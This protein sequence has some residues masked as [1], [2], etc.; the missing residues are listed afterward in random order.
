MHLTLQDLRTQYIDY[1]V[2]I[3]N[4]LKRLG[5]NPPV[6]LNEQ[7][8]DE[9]EAE[10]GLVSQKS[11]PTNSLSLLRDP[12]LFIG[13]TGA[14]ADVTH[15]K[16]GCVNEQENRALSVEIDGETSRCASQVDLPGIKCDK[17]G[18]ELQHVTLKKMRY[19]P[20]ANF[21]LLSLTK[22]LMDG[23]TMN[24]DAKEI[25]MRKGSTQIR[26]DIVIKT[27]RGAIF[28]TYIKHRTVPDLQRGRYA[29]S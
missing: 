25:V 18:N 26:F 29:S 13:D 6:D 2:I 3:A 8:T 19:N 5:I 27:E 12:N 7:S 20:K 4:E 10:L 9:E 28:A 23:W 24:G 1:R 15:D 21:N 11:F 16:I 22:L 14:T 17:H